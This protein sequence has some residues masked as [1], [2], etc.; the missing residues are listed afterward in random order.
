MSLMENPDLIVMDLSLP[1]SSGL[2]TAKRIKENS[3]TSHIPIVACSGWKSDEILGQAAEAGI[4]EAMRP[5]ADLSPPGQAKIIHAFVTALGLRDVTLGGDGTLLWASH[6]VG[7]DTPIVAINTAPRDS[8][9]YFCAGNKHEIDDVVPPCVI[10]ALQR[11]RLSHRQQQG[12]G[13]ASDGLESASAARHEHAVEILILLQLGQ[14]RLLLGGQFMDALQLQP[15]AGA[16][17]HQGPGAD[18]SLRRRSSRRER[19]FSSS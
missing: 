15:G 9:G 3:Q 19:S 14:R 4:V 13:R 5:E 18:H 11:R 1:D 10:S 12:G 6:L 8:V 17:A 16:E 2:E 7:A